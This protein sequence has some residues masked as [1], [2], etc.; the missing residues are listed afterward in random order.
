[1]THGIRG[2]AYD[3]CKSAMRCAQRPELQT[4]IHG[5]TVSS[6]PPLADGDRSM[7]GYLA[8]QQ[9]AQVAGYLATDQ[10][11]DRLATQPL[12]PPPALEPA[13]VQL[14]SGFHR[15]FVRM[16]SACIEAVLPGRQAASRILDPYHKLPPVSVTGGIEVAMCDDASLSA[17]AREFALHVGAT[18]VRHVRIPGVEDDLDRMIEATRVLEQHV[19]KTGPLESPTDVFMTLA[20]RAGSPQ[21]EMMRM[22]AAFMCL[23]ASLA[24]LDQLVFQA[25]LK[26]RL[27]A[28]TL[29]NVISVDKSVHR[30]AGTGWKLFC[31]LDDVTAR[32]ECAS[33]ALL[34]GLPGLDGEN[35]LVSVE[36]TTTSMAGPVG[37]TFE[38]EARG[39]DGDLSPYGPMLA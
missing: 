1:M 15:E 28:I 9:H 17:L 2:A 33:L 31:Q 14:L 22:V 39:I 38:F 26:D 10:Y 24:V 30:I 35:A 8:R 27:P 29:D 34:V 12:G 3:L 16:N 32:I 7:F 18:V 5:L 36:R 21:R 19:V 4:V 13:E 23:R 37:A 6:N 11:R 25:L 20:D